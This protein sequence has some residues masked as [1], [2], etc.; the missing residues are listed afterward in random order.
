M[1]YQFNIFKRLFLLLND[2]LYFY[3]YMILLREFIGNFQY[4][5][6]KNE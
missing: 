5:L 6:E 4:F 2:I 1:E 3:T